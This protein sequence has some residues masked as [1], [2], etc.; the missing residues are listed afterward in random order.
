MPGRFR[1][2]DRASVGHVEKHSMWLG[3]T[4]RPYVESVLI[5]HRSRHRIISHRKSRIAIQNLHLEFWNFAILPKV[6]SKF[7]A[8]AES[9]AVRMVTA[10]NRARNANKLSFD[11][12]AGGVNHR[13]A[14]TSHV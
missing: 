10:L 1:L 14:V 13:I 7:D 8:I 4:E 11:E 6:S 2:F 12:T 5:V 9:T 3:R